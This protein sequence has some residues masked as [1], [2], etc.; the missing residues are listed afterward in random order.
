M[1]NLPSLSLHHAGIWVTDFDMMVAFYRALF[2]FHVSDEGTYPDGG[3]VIFLTID[4]ASH[5]T[6]VIGEGRPEG[7]P[8]TINQLSFRTDGLA[9]VRSFWQVLEG[10]GAVARKYTRCHGNAWSV[11]FW[12]PEDNR[13]EIFADTP[14]H[15]N[16]P[17]GEPIDFTLDDAEIMRF[18][19]ELVKK[20]PSYRP[21]D[22]WRADTAAALRSR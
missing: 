21:F 7:A 20:D 11:Y 9:A 3:R 6:F 15:V 14:W 4:P 16:Q 17:F 18:T 13:I 2:G 22:D 8:S 19:E 12:D 1:A 5:H 10:E